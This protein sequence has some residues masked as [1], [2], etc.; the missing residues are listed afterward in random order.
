[1]PIEKTPSHKAVEEEQAR[2]CA[3]MKPQVIGS[4]KEDDAQKAG[5][6]ENA[7]EEKQSAGR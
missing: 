1:M 4:D 7:Y 2:Q 6:S 3:A 5:S